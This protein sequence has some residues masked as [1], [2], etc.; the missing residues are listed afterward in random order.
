MLGNLLRC[1]C[2]RFWVTANRF[3]PVYLLWSLI[4]HNSLQ[5][6]FILSDTFCVL[7]TNN[8][9]HFHFSHFTFEVF[10]ILQKWQALNYATLSSYYYSYNF[11]LLL[12]LWYKVTYNS[13]H[14]LTLSKSFFFFP[15]T[16]FLI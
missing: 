16:F 1:A 10:I 5:F 15:Y 11:L 12:M 4:D 13:T 6:C 14:F 3:L 8:S 2:L 7:N 9:I